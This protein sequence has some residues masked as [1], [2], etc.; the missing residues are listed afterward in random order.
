[1]LLAA[2]ALSGTLWATR[3]RVEAVAQSDLVIA[4]V[5]RG[6]LTRSVR[7]PGVVVPIEIRWLA[8][9]VEGKVERKVIEV[10]E[11]VHPHSLILEMSSPTLSR[12]LDTARLDLAVQESQLMVSEKQL[13]AD[14]L[15]QEALI[16]DY[17]QRYESARVKMEANKAARDS[18]ARLVVQDSEIAAARFGN[19]VEIEKTKLTRM[20]E[21]RDARIQANKAELQR[22]RR[23]VTLAQELVDSLS[24]RA[25]IEGTL[26][27]LPVEAGQQIGVGTRLARVAGDGR[28]KVE[29]RVQEQQAK[30]I[31]I[32]QGVLI[33]A[34]GQEGRGKVSR[35]DPAVQEGTVLVDAQFTDGALTGARTDLRVQGLIETGVVNNTLVVQRPTLIDENST[36]DLFVV[37]ATRR[38]AERRSVEFGM[39]SSDK[40]QVT[41]GLN[42]GE[43]IVVSDVS[44]YA[45]QKSITLGGN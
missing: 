14:I 7:A 32:G 3:D 10:G 45:G 26:Q 35:I 23:Q 5:E 9:I 27:D 16:A 42:E 34:G 25:G 28:Y 40:I 15:T 19:R 12:N 43:E 37:N 31:R 39:G 24:V 38:S 30:E 29:L 44:S 8:A 2:V 21:I 1:M 36:H 20:R 4:R 18:I 22:A 17:D 41:R 6:D 11:K 33:T 13:D